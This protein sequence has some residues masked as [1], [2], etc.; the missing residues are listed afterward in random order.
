[1]LFPG[2]LFPGGLPT[3]EAQYVLKDI[4]LGAA[5]AVVA[6]RALGRPLRPRA[7][8]HPRRSAARLPRG[9]PAGRRKVG[10]PWVLTS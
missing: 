1:V 8:I 6:A 5:A 7:L 3:L 10:R 2:D 4:V 9:L